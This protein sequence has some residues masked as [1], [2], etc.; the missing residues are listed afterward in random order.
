MRA[1]PSPQ[2]SGGARSARLSAGPRPRE[3]LWRA[4]AGAVILLRM[5]TPYA[6]LALL[7]AP[8]A[9]RSDEGMWTF[10]DFPAAKVEATYGFRTDDRW[11]E[12]VRLSSARLAQGCSGSFVSASGLVMTNHHCAHLCIEQ[13]STSQRD[14]VK[15]GFY[16]KASADEVKCP[17][18]EVNQLVGISDVTARMRKATD[19]LE[20]QR[21]NEAQRAVIARVEKECQTSDRLRCE[22]VTLYHGGRYD[23]YKYRRF[24]DV[25][26]VFAPE[27][28]IAFFGGDP[29]NFEFPRYDLD[30]SFVRVYE[31]GK[32]ARMEHFFR[33]SPAGARE[34][35]LTFVTG[36]PGG[37][38]RQLTVA[39]LVYARDVQLP[40]TLFRLSELRG[41]L[42]EYRRRGP[43][44]ARHSNADLFYVEN[45]VKA[46]KGRLEALHD[47]DF[48]ASKV[49]AERDLT[50]QLGK[51]PQKAQRYVPA[52]DAIA[53]AQK[54]LKKIRKPLNFVERRQGFMGELYG[55]ARALVRGGEERPKPSEQRL[56]EYR[57][58]ALPALTQ[59]LFSAAPIF[60]EFEIFQLSFS[61]TKLREALGVDDPFVKKVLGK[62]SPAEVAE[63]LV[64]GTKLSDVAYRKKLWEGGKGAVEAAAKGDAMIE[65]ALRVDPD[66]RAVR[67]SYEDGIESVLKRNDEIIAKARFEVQGTSTYPDATFTP[68]LS[69]G[70]VKGYEHDGKTVKPFTTLAGAFERDTGR[71][72]FALPKSWHDAKARLDLAMPFDFVTTNDI[73]GGNSGS[74]V[75]NKDAQIVGLIFDGNVHSLGG[76]YGFDPSVNRAIA[77]HSAG[78]LE[79]LSK[80]YAAERV[81]QEIRPAHGSGGR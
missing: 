59:T 68:R 7:V 81:V 64:K 1:A 23:L 52:F 42:T 28:A 35:E 5:K 53:K 80:V 4:S 19:G 18:L 78:I 22:V 34:D 65:L 72:P 67:K 36:N 73:I 47:A 54:D 29:D 24:Q 32:P 70:A 63:R 57:D 45:S 33:W 11:L 76:D 2:A 62:A 69:Y 74:P 56:K 15:T 60:D 37:T 77:V 71:E 12:H 13:L 30:L 6:L 16:A 9:A 50:A 25:R 55:Y 75:V 48:F 79:A 41:Q 20:G 14:F 31:D 49:A 46:L 43:E 39:Q 10:N 21:Y 61:L 58:S 38:S 27:L 8:L 51:D 26:L 44:Q 17:E 40:D 66:A 3:F